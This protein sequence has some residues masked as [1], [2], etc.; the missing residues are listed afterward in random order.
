MENHDLHNAR[1]KLHLYNLIIAAVLCGVIAACLSPLIAVW[2]AD[3]RR[4]RERNEFNSRRVS[5]VSMEKLCQ[6]NFL[7]LEDDRCTGNAL[8]ITYGVI[9]GIINLQIY[10]LTDYQVVKKRLEAFVDECNVERYP[11]FHYQCWYS[12]DSYWIRLLY[13]NDYQLQYPQGWD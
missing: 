13:L 2:I 6:N 1:I 9:P 11:S 4:E 8:P 5:D 7:P 3:A 12:I 10:G